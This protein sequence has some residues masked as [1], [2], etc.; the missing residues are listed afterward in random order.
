MKIGYLGPIGTYSHEAACSYIKAINEEADCVAL[1][2]F[3]AIVDMVEQGQVERGIIPVENSTHGAVAT[4]MDTLLHVSRSKIC[5]EITLKIDHC[6]LSTAKTI[7]DIRYVYSHEQA[8]EQCSQFFYKQNPH[9]EVRHCPSTAQACAL[10]LEN[11]GEYGAVASLSAAKRYELDVL[12][13]TIQDNPFNQTR[14]LVIGDAYPEITGIDKTSII[15]AFADDRSGSLY[16]VLHSFASR[17]INLTRIESRPAKHSVG[18]YIFYLDFQGHRDEELGRE[19]LREIKE[20]VSWLKVLGSYP[21]GR[22]QKES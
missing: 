10:A 11:G 14:F 5:G 6:L 16:H 21:V 19:V 3:R 20:Q 13:E 18:Q 8:L 2:N 9:I 12:A 7:G 1:P 22:Q 17:D 4:A 15:L